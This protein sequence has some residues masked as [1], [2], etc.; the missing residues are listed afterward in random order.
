MSII[1]SISV[2]NGDMFY[3]KHGSSNFTIIDCNMDDTNKQ[4]I[5][6]EIISE[7]NNKDITRFIS[8]HP[9]E[10][11]IHGLKYLDDKIGILNF[12]CVKNEA[13]KS[14]E[15]DDF[16][17]YCEL[18]DSDKKAFY[19]YEGCSRCWMNQNDEEKKYGSSGIN[20]LWPITDNEDYK[21]ELLNA[22]EGKSPNNISPIIKYSLSNGVTVLWF[23]DLENS[24]MEKIKDTVELPEADIIFAPHH[25]RSS[26][27]I[28]KEWMESI[29][30]IIVIIGEAPSEK[31]NYLSNYNTITQN[32]AGDIIL[33]CESGIVDIYV[34]NE[35]YSV[36]FLENN[37]KSNAYGATYIGTLNV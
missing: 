8:T 31:I 36:K 20:I 23:G 35:N 7:S 12:Y 26:G 9:D 5:T 33:D 28:P 4:K 2:G 34:S 13:T 3:I 29:S 21:A 37:K 27:K 14:D 15:T 32:T 10:D 16:K 24:F 30:P 11:H 1:K 19:I 6:D 25:G 22:K 18:R 17:K